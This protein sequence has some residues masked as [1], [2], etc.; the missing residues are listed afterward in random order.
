M[1]LEQKFEGGDVGDSDAA[2]DE[3]EVD[4]EDAVNVVDVEDVGHIAHG[5]EQHDLEIVEGVE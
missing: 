3:D 4:T 1:P 5:Q 2:V